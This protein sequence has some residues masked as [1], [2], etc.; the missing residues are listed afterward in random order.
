MNVVTFQ[1]HWIHLT[2]SSLSTRIVFFTCILCFCPSV[3]PDIISIEMEVADRGRKV[4][5]EEELE[6][7]KKESV[8]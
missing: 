5:R 1:T 7:E 6:G 8:Y 2:L 3:M 4:G